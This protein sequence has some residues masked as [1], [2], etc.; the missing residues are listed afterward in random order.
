[1]STQQRASSCHLLLPGKY[2]KDS[3]P[4]GPR[5]QLFKE[6]L[7]QVEPVLQVG[8]SCCCW[9]PAAAGALLLLEPCC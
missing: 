7:P 6:L 8:P 4:P 9:S 3:L 5:G 2:S 1:M